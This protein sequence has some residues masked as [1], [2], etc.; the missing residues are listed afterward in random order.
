MFTSGMALW[1][2]QLFPPLG[3][4]LPPPPL[5]KSSLAHYNRQGGVNTVLVMPNLIPPVTTVQ[6]ALEYKAGWESI[7][8]GVCSTK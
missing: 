6:Q 7:Y 8:I 5:S 3:S 2:K 1:Q 4:N